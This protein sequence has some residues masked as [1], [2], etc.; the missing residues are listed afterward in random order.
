MFPSLDGLMAFID[1]LLALL[2]REEPEPITPQGKVA[3]LLTTYAGWN[4]HEAGYGLCQNS[5]CFCKLP[6]KIATVFAPR[7]EGT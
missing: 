5:D 1:D 2:R 7:L 3:F 6:E 4:P